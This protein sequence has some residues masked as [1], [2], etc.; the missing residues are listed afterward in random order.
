MKRLAAGALA[1]CILAGGIAALAGGGSSSDP[2]ISKSYI[3][4]TFIPGTVKEASAKIS[5]ALGRVY[6]GVHT[7]L[8]ETSQSFQGGQGEG[9]P[10][11][12]Q[13]RVKRGDLLRMDSGAQAVLLAGSATVSFEKGVL[14]DVTEGSE[15]PSGALLALQHRYLAA[16]DTRCYLAVTSDTAVIAPQGAC[17]LIKSRETDYNALADA[18]KEMGMFRGSGIS[19]GDGYELERAPTRIEG[20]ILF[21]RLLGEEEQALAYLGECPFAD[22][23]EWS[24]PYV[25][26][27]FEKG[28]TKGV[29]G[30]GEKQYFN[31]YGSITSLEYEIFVLRALGYQDGDGGD[32]T[33]D[34]ALTKAKELGCLTAGEYSLLTQKPFLRAQVAYV[35][36]YALDA[37]RKTG[38]T[39]LDHLAAAGSLDRNLVDTVRRG[40]SVT[41]VN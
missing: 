37:R 15:V 25:G 13:Q 9:A 40:V 20:L 27:A 22:V 14:V 3:N 32:F 29:G 21:L 4:E 23:Q 26:Y 39:L 33:W 35:S 41:R 11:F 36:Y 24:R 16:E 18:L 8:E 30:D 2:F 38:E 28:Y 12:I 31:P 10:F 7:S 17:S 34:A 6:D 19:Y 5:A 1:A